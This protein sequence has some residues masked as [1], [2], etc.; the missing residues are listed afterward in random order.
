MQDVDGSMKFIQMLSFDM[1]KCTRCDLITESNSPLLLLKSRER[2][3][4]LS[5]ISYD[6]TESTKYIYGRFVLKNKSD[7]INGKW[8]GFY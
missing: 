2:I 1:I 6:A 5:I 7:S 3:G 8:H 4:K